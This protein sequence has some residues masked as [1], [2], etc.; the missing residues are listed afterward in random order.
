[1]APNDPDHFIR[2]IINNAQSEVKSIIN[3]LPS[4]LLDLC[5]TVSTG[6]VV[7][8]RARS[9]LRREPDK[10]TVP[11]IYP[12]HFKGGFV[13]WPKENSRKPNA[14][15]RVE[16][17]RELLVPAGTYVL[18]KRFSSKEEMRRVVASIYDPEQIQAPLVGFENHLN[19]YHCQ[20]HGMPIN[21]AKGLAAFLNSTILDEYF[22]QFSGHTQVN[23]TDLR[24]LKY[25]HKESLEMLGR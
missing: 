17:T 20:G 12:T 11:L 25:P 13:S 22:R 21:L 8:F 16:E 3:R 5:L 1:M 24:V 15:L 4:L 23:A 6:R 7:D 18:V 19:Y 10:N 14:I 9:Y 2:V